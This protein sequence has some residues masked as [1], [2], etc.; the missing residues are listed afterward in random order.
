MSLK[1]TIVGTVAVLSTLALAGC[2]NATDISGSQGATLTKENFASA[3]DSATAQ[4]RSVH[5]SGTVSA[6]GQ[7][8]TLS[9]D[10]SLGGS[11]LK[12]LTGAMTMTLPGMGQMQARF[13][14]GTIYLN[15]AN[16]GLPGS[17]GKPWMKID[18]TDPSNPLGAAFSKIAALN[19]SQM[20]DTFKSI[21]T[22]TTVGSETVDGI[23]TTHYKVAVDTAKV[24]NLMGLSQNQRSDLASMPKTLT[25]DVWVD[26]T[27]RPVKL[28]M[29][30]Q[31][32]RMEM[33]FSK[34]G[35]PVHVVAPPAS[36]VR[37]FSL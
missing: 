14:S 28:S 26:G 18:L 8:M 16:L 32:M 23:Q 35:E 17:A 20:M 12:D 19:P 15:V 11:S 31:T 33:H 27:S 7:Q 9:A 21:T 3:M 36:Q 34:W 22:L 5:I 6:A 37:S 4:A 10:E 1:K 2:G 30:I 25:Y 24:A 29:A 13:V